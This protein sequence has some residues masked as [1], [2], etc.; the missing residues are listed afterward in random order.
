MQD[1]VPGIKKQQIPDKP[2]ILCGHAVVGIALPADAQKFIVVIDRSF[3]TSDCP[4]LCIT[5]ADF[6]L[7]GIAANAHPRVAIYIDVFCSNRIVDKPADTSQGIGAI[8]VLPE[9]SRMMA[10]FSVVARS[11][12]IEK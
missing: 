10:I 2:Y 5:P 4:Y 12:L 6:D 3:L 9:L 11:S 7:F 8:I 1:N